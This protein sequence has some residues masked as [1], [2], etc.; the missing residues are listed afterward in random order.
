MTT[1]DFKNTIKI[2]LESTRSTLKIANSAEEKLLLACSDIH[3]TED[4]RTMFKILFDLGRGEVEDT[5]LLLST[6]DLNDSR[7]ES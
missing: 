4:E 2:H 3:I 6:T 7:G 5:I 1:Q